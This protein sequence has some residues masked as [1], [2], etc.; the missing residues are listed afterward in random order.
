[1]L[2]CGDLF[3]KANPCQLTIFKT[4]EIFEKNIISDK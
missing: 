1:M 2:Q 4:F 3:D